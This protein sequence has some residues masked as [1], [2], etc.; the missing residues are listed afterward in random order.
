MPVQNAPGEGIWIC[1]SRLAR[2]QAREGEEGLSGEQRNHIHR[3]APL[4][5]DLFYLLRGEQHARSPAHHKHD[6]GAIHLLRDRADRPGSIV[7]VQLHAF[8]RH[9]C[10]LCFVVGKFQKIPR[11][12][13]VLPAR[14]LAS[15]LR[16][17]NKLQK[18]QAGVHALGKSKSRGNGVCVDSMREWQQ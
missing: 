17:L 9:A 6:P 5:Q 16:L 12:L 10:A 8:N 3:Q 7:R 15:S 2:Q 18:D 11:L 13:D 4:L 1:F 14:R